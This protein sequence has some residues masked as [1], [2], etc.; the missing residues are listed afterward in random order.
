M[1]MKKKLVGICIIFL[2]SAIALFNFSSNTVAITGTS[3]DLRAEGHTDTIAFNG[4]NTYDTRGIADYISGQFQFPSLD[5]IL[6]RGRFTILKYNNT[7]PFTF[8]IN[9]PINDTYTNSTS[10]TFSWTNTT[11]PDKDIVSYRLEIFN[12]SA[13]T[14][15]NTINNS[16]VEIATPTEALVTLA[17]DGVYFYRIL[18]NDSSKNSSFTDLR[19]ITI[20]TTLPTAFN[21]T[22]LANGTSTQDNTPLLEWDATTETNLENYTIELSLNETFDSI[23]TTENSSTNT[24]S[25]WTAVLPPETYYWRVTAVDKANNQQLSE[26]NFSFTIT[27]VSQTVTQGGG[28]ISVAG[29]AS[30]KPY[31]FH[32][33]APPSITVF[34]GETITIPLEIQNLGKDINLNNIVLRAEADPTITATLDKTLINTLKPSSSVISNL[35]IQS[36]GDIG[37][38]SVTVTADAFLPRLHDAVKI[39]TNIIGKEGPD[40]NSAQ[41][42]IIFAKKLFDGNPQCKDLLETINQAEQE[43]ERNSVARALELTSEAINKCKELISVK[44][45]TKPSLFNITFNVIKENKTASVISAQVLALLVIVTIVVKRFI[46]KKPKKIELDF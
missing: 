27:A 39:I 7:A 25:S 42:Q 9:A 1:Y 34:Q 2:L 24:F 31:S 17:T 40:E 22:S 41:Q 35:I 33:I 46:G 11:D 29:G 3:G 4:T 12:D 32:I 21:L 18:A 23:N 44:T 16:I 10:V 37:T 15:E 13:L 36:T 5:D 38:F 19:T 30:P 28:S 6:L 8:S 45:G 20:D 43:L 14:L 26:N